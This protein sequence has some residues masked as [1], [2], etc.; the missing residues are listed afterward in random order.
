[1]VS[2]FFHSL[3]VLHQKY[4]ALSSCYTAVSAQPPIELCLFTDLSITCF[5]KSIVT[6]DCIELE[7]NKDIFRPVCFLK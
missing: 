7:V 5:S 4:K 3:S 1:M 2:G 6:K